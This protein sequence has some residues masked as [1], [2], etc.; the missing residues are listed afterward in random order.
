MGKLLFNTETFLS[1]KDLVEG[2]AYIFKD[3][4][5]GYY[6]GKEAF[7]EKFVFYIVASVYFCRTDSYY[8]QTLSHYNTQVKD[9][10]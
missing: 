9:L 10:V 4:R 7:Q 2:N 6:L 5:L 8:T 3:G 1:K